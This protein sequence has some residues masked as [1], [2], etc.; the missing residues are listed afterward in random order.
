MFIYIASVS[1]IDT[2]LVSIV[3]CLVLSCFSVLLSGVVLCFGA[4]CF[5]VVWYDLLCCHALCLTT[6]TVLGCDV[7]G[8]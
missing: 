2:V 4:R 7:N 8:S 3:F 5:T 1:S 6:V